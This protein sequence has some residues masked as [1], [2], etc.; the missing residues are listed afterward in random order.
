MDL[1]HDVNCERPVTTIGA[2]LE[3]L[4]R[5]EYGSD[6][7]MPHDSRAVR[8]VRLYL[9]SGT[10]PCGPFAT[11]E[12]AWITTPQARAMSSLLAEHHAHGGPAQIHARVRIEGVFRVDTEKGDAGAVPLECDLAQIYDVHVDGRRCFEEFDSPLDTV[13]LPAYLV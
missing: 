9:L 12:R 10:P 11:V 6:L 7:T 2:H 1:Q 4:A 13:G 5:I 8:A 3:C